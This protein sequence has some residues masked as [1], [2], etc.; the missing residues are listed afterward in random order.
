MSDLFNIIADKTMGVILGGGLLL[1]GS[2][3][4]INTFLREDL[5]EKG[6][7]EAKVAKYVMYVFF[8]LFIVR[9]VLGKTIGRLAQQK[10]ADK[11]RVAKNTV[12]RLAG[13]SNNEAA[14]TLMARR[15][16]ISSKPVVGISLALAAFLVFDM[17]EAEKKGVPRAAQGTKAMIFTA[18]LIFLAIGQVMKDSS[19]S[20]VE[21]ALKISVVK[22]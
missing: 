9:V 14:R 22:K 12:D 20:A 18:I 11:L 15:R 2:W 17:T 5:G 8:A 3:W 7:K 16:F 6:K 19:D 4:A 21:K 1:S 13:I 10:M